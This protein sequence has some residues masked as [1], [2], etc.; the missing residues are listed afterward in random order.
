MAIFSFGKKENKKERG[1]PG[2]P[3][4]MIMSMKQRGL[5]DNSIIG[6]LEKQG[7]NS[8]QIFD[9][10]NQGNVQGSAP[11]PMPDPGMPSQ[12][13][14]PPSQDMP[15]DNMP[16]PPQ[17]AP[18]PEPQEP[19]ISKDQ[20]EE[21]AEAIIDEKWKEFEEDVQKIID[22]KN[23]TEVRITQ[24]Q[25]H[26]ED[27]SNNVNS[28]HKNLVNKIDDY[29]GNIKNV[30]VEIKAMEKVF[31]KVLPSLTENVNKLERLSKGPKKK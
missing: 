28:L 23:Q 6:E 13:N 2:N 19:S 21:I 29:D 1:A 25:Q 5:D 7:Y 22:W 20:I 8:S 26:L 27:L 24:F 31:Q 9:A 15:F 11:G 10:M 30:G 3:V 18:P 4:D 12:D 14:F 16:P 17:H